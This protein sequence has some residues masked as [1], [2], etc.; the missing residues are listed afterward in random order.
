MSRIL[1]VGDIHEPVAHPGYLSFCED[2]YDQWDCGQ[3]IF[4]G[5]IVDHH[6]I[7]F[8]TH[9]PD[10]PGPSDEY[11]LSLEKIQ[12]WYE[13]FPKARVC[14]G[15]HDARI[16]RL[17][18]SV[19]IPSKFLRDY[20][21]TWDTPG[22]DW[23]Y[24][25][26]VEDVY[27]FHGEGCSGLY[28]AANAGKKMSLNVCM[29]HVHTAFGVTYWAN[30]QRR[31]WAASTGCGIDD[32]AAAFAYGKHFKLRSVLGAVVVVDGTPYAEPMPVGPKERYH[33]SKFK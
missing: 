3:V 24:E 31:F 29:G 2:L 18:E 12:G 10:C 9:H 21:E 6:A 17:A 7:S 16:V 8:H 30:P 1:V 23:Q 5:D 13:A 22:W 26:L 4:I 28:P 25:H 11:E 20:A 14:I 33:R 32:R 15:N 27:Y 19:N